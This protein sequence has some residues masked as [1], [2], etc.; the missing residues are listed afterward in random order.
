[1]DWDEGVFEGGILTFT[2]TDG[3]KPQKKL[4]QETGKPAK[5]HTAC[6]EYKSTA[7]PLHQFTWFSIGV[8]H[9]AV[10]VIITLLLHNDN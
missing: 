4:Y 9:N 8:I 5:I 2:W 7:L 3:G 6:P 1:M 10:K